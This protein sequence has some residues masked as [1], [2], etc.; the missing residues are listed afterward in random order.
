[1]EYEANYLFACFG[2]R[3]KYIFGLTKIVFD[4]NGRDFYFNY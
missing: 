4:H 3:R 1:M 2:E